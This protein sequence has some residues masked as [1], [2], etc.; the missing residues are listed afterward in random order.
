[1]KK[2]RIPNY[3]Y[4][5]KRGFTVL[6]SIVAIM[7]LSL[8]IAGVFSAVQTSLSQAAIAKDE[9]RAF[10][11]AQEAIESLRNQRDANQLLRINTNNFS[12]GWLTNIAEDSGDPC[13]FG[14]VCRVDVANIP[15]TFSYCGSAWDSCPNLKQDQSLFLYN[16]ASGNDT[17]IKR[18]MQLEY[19]SNDE[20]SVTVKIKWNKGILNRTFEVKTHLFNWI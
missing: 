11:L 7:I 3:K 5:T 14:K 10:Y 20:I 12:Y 9:V 13:Y 16:Y 17:N 2:F 6:E 18:E 19:I 1:M 4:Q 15:P 8:A